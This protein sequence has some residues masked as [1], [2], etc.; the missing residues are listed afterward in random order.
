M[1]FMWMEE[2]HFQLDGRIDRLICSKFMN[3]SESL[4]WGLF[5]CHGTLYNIEKKELWNSMN[6]LASIMQMP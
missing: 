3:G 2:M 5:A 6:Q 1:V 4:L